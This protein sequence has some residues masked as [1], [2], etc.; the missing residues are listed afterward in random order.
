MHHK[1]GLLAAA[2]RLSIRG[3]KQSLG[4]DSAQ[5]TDLESSGSDITD[6]VDGA[7]IKRP[8]LPRLS[9]KRPL[10]AELSGSFRSN[11]VFVP[12]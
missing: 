8:V 12:P 6:I 9:R 11:F 3:P 2:S 5:T 7:M 4:S 10:I 1:S